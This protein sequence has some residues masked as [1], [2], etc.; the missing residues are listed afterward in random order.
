MLIVSVSAWPFSELLSSDSEAA[1]ALVKNRRAGRPA[2]T[3]LLVISQLELVPY[4]FGILFRVILLVDR[5]QK[6][7]ENF[8]FLQQ[9]QTIA[10]GLQWKRHISRRF[11][12]FC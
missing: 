4:W 1:V 3:R 6:L 5:L 9:I 10:G 7:E 8:W 2:V 12:E 11:T